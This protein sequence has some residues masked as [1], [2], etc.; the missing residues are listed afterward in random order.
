MRT[1][2]QLQRDV[3]DELRW[4]PAVGDA[5]IGVA[6]KDGVVTLAGEVESFARRF[7]AVKAAERV[8]GIRAIAEDIHVKIPS[9]TTRTDTEIA[10]AAANALEWDV[11]VPVT[12]V[13]ARVQDGWVWLEGDVEWQYQRVAAERAV[14]YLTGVKGVNNVL[15]IAPKLSVSDVKDRIQRALQRNAEVESK[16]ISIETA[17][18]GKVVLR[19]TVHSFAERR[20]AENA[21]WSAPGVRE[22]DDEL[23]VVT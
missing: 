5:E 17:A 2:A 13:K 6:V 7:A 19:G 8:A 16:N 9:A 14:R 22:V 3:M 4:D 1:D 11:E 20:D 15:R 18:D 23:A 12:G 10:H 21:A